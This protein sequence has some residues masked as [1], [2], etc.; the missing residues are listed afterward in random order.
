MSDY[1]EPA[2]LI[3]SLAT[4]GGALGAGLESDDAVRQAAYSYRLDRADVRDRTAHQADTGR[5]AD[6]GV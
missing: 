6:H 5:A 4:V 3:S 1:L 2:W